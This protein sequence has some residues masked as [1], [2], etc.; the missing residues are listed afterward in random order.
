MWRRITPSREAQRRAM[1]GLLRRA[2]MR[3]MN[4]AE[5]RATAATK[6]KV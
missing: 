1:P 4:R 6:G 3:S 5:R 2:L